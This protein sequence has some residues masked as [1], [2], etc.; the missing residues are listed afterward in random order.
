MSNVVQYAVVGN[1]CM[2][3]E[4]DEEQPKDRADNPREVIDRLSV[5]P[6]HEGFRRHRGYQITIQT[7]RQ[8]A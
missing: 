3:Q 2:R 6:A 8:G 4:G 5:W 1:L 7:V